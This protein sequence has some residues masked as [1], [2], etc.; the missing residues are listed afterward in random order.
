MGS[1][2]DIG[3]S[4]AGARLK[5]AAY[6]PKPEGVYEVGGQM[7][8]YGA[9][10]APEGARYQGTPGTI[11]QP[12]EPPKPSYITTTPFGSYVDITKPG[13]F[14]AYSE[15]SSKREE[16]F[17]ELSPIEPSGWEKF[18]QSITE[19]PYSPF[20]LYKPVSEFVSSAIGSV[21]G[22]VKELAENQ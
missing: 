17:S 15:T 9:G 1:I 14:K 20:K 22:S 8:S 18:G 10:K 3:Y 4:K 2:L 5:R 13:G 7:F 19:A 12:T 11:V 6:E 16:I 21:A